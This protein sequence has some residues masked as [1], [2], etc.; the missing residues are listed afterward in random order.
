MRLP[1]PSLLPGSQ[2]EVFWTPGAGRR[3][4]QVAMEETVVILH[5][6]LLR[7]RSS[8]VLS[9]QPVDIGEVV[10]KVSHWGRSREALQTAGPSGCR[11]AII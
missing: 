11:C 1:G 8:L 7:D 3:H 10:V 6:R 4:W 9:V 2:M 5:G